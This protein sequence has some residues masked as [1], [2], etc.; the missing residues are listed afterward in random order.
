MVKIRW[1]KAT[2]CLVLAFAQVSLSF[3]YLI[4]KSPASTA[5]AHIVYSPE[6]VS[7]KEK[8]SL[9]QLGGNFVAF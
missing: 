8:L 7:I 3:D 1:S 2:L 5:S 6:K 9:K 4:K